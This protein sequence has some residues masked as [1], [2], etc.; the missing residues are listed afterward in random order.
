MSRIACFL[1]FPNWAPACAGEGYGVS[2]LTY[3]K[4]VLTS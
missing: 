2:V 4:K 3:Q 1:L